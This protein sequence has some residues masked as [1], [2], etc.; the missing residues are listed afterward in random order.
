[1]LNSYK[2]RIKE[3]PSCSHQSQCFPPEAANAVNT[4]M[5]HHSQHEIRDLLLSR[6]L[7]I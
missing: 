6:P 3:N 1:M 4:H 2:V 7:L 5:R